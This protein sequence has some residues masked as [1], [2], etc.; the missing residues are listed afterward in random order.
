MLFLLSGE[1][2]QSETHDSI[3]DAKT[4]L[5][6]YRKYEELT[7]AKR[8]ATAVAELYDA[9]RNCGWKVPGSEEE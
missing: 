3:E 1:K 4:A 7:K 9:G 2:I 6:L 5:L 8:V